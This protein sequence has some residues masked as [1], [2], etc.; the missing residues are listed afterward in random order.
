MSI[1]FF[2]SILIWPIVQCDQ[3]SSERVVDQELLSAITMNYI[4]R[5][6]AFI[7]VPQYNGKFLGRR[8]VGNRTMKKEKEKQEANIV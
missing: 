3:T 8:H 2:E 4:T 1:D 5:I 7:R 6:V